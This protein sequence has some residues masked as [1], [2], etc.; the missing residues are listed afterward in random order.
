MRITVFILFMGLCLVSAKYLRYEPSDS[1]LLLR[2]KRSDSD[3]S[4]TSIDDD[5]GDDDEDTGENNSLEKKLKELEIKKREK[6]EKEK[7]KQEEKQRKLE[8]K[9]AKEQR[10]AEEKKEKE[11]RKRQQKLEKEEEKRQKL[12]EKEQEDNKKRVEKKRKE[13]EKIRQELNQDSE[14]DNFLNTEEESSI[15]LSDIWRHHIY[16]KY[17]LTLSSTQLEKQAALRRYLQEELGLSPNSTETERRDA[18]IKLIQTK[19]QENARA[20]NGNS[21]LNNQLLSHLNAISI[22]KFK[23]K[24][25]KDIEKLNNKSSVLSNVNLTWASE[26]K[27]QLDGKRT[28]LQTIAQYLSSVIPNWLAGRPSITASTNAT[29]EQSLDNNGLNGNGSENLT[30]SPIGNVNDNTVSAS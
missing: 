19:I 20:S 29:V 7:R 5:D 12:L 26:A 18:I 2:Y 14:G 13:I 27:Q 6:E 30:P 15:E 8:E 3:E 25:D 22:Q 23:L 17:G 16:V 4:V 28:L 21:Q 24:L 11:E 9:K 10:K 1:N